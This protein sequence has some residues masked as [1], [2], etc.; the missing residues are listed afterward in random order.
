MAEMTITTIS[1]MSVNPAALPIPL[2]M[3]P[4]L[5]AAGPFARIRIARCVP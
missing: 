1:S 5:R 2:R 4:K 3:R